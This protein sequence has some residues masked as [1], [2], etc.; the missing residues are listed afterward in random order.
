[1]HKIVYWPRIALA[2]AQIEARLR[3]IGQVRLVV[4]SSLEHLLAELPNATGLV[5]PDAPVDQARQITK[6]LAEPD[7]TVRWMHFITAGR[8]GF[9]AAG[10][11]SKTAITWPRGAVAPT[12]AEH[13]MTLLLAL[14]RRV[15]DMLAAAGKGH[16]DT[17]L[18]ARADAIEGKRLLIVGFGQIGREV[19]TRANAF[20]MRVEAVSRTVRAEPGL[21][22]MYP[23]SALDERLAVADAIVLC[24]PLSPDTHHLIDARRLALCLPGAYLINVGRGGL[25]DPDALASALRAHRLAGAGL[26]VTEPE[27]LPPGHALWHT[28]RIIIS[29]HLAGGGSPA[30][31]NR[32]ADGAAENCQRL[33]AGEPLLDRL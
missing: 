32:L 30:S 7:A 33:L 27:P 23:L 26:D 22:A 31:M 18:S 2:Q 6:A 25:V 14:A 9:E 15:P 20:G 24:A 29:P 17:T 19:A 10:M 16:W 5:L 8:N 3:A 21:E 28:G 11:P 1:M 12:V 13:A 4:A